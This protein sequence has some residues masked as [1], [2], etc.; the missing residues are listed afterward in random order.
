MT[1]SE[2]RPATTA[3]GHPAAWASAFNTLDP[4]NTDKF[5]S[6]DTIFIPEP[7]YVLKGPGPLRAAMQ[8]FMNLGLPI[9]ERIRH[10]Y[11]SNGI[12]LVIVDW[13]VEGEANGEYVSLSGTGADVI[14]RGSD[15][16]WRYL[17]DNPFGTA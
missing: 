14:Q 8:E 3:E 4:D 10:V 16:R 13:K 12:A 5:N 15:G 11:E 9:Q 6:E 1:T 17:I 7:G 2:Y